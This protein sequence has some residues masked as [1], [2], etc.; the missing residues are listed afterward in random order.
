MCVCARR[1]AIAGFVQW[2][3]GTRKNFYG[4]YSARV[5]MALHLGFNL[6]VLPILLSSEFERNQEDPCLAGE[7]PADLCVPA[8][9]PRQAYLDAVFRSRATIGIS[10]V[11]FFS[12]MF[13][14]VEGPGLTLLEPLF[15]LAPERLRF[16][17]VGP[18]AAP[19]TYSG[20]DFAITNLLMVWSTILFLLLTWK[21]NIICGWSPDAFPW[22][23]PDY[24]D[25]K[26]DTLPLTVFEQEYADNPLL[27]MT[28]YVGSLAVV[29]GF[30][31]AILCLAFK[32]KPPP[33]S[34]DAQPKEGGRSA[35]V[36]PSRVA[37]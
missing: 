26:C 37:V 3:A 24:N 30:S 25:G 9:T 35:N 31:C 32:L 8:R 11:K 13:S 28:I 6:M 20:R 27:V 29:I 34:D 17:R 21:Y 16:L 19:Q 22:S 14:L 7:D 5:N 10:Q 36:K 15:N 33:A 1:A 23:L 12:G 2:T 18:L 4:K